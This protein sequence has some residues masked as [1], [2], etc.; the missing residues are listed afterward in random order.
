MTR[1]QSVS[2]RAFV[3]PKPEVITSLG[4]LRSFLA[5]VCSSARLYVE[6]HGHRLSRQGDLSLIAVRAYPHPEVYVIDIQ[7]L[8]HEAFTTRSVFGLTLQSI[9]ENKGLRKVFWDVRD[10]ADALWGHHGVRLEGV[11]DLQLLE[12]ASRHSPRCQGWGRRGSGSASSPSQ[13]YVN[14]LDAA[15]RRDLYLPTAEREHIARLRRTV[16]CRLPL[17]AFRLRP[18]DDDTIAFCANGIRYLP[19]LRTVYMERITCEWLPK[20]KVETARRLEAAFGPPYN[21]ESP[22]RTLGPWGNEKKPGPLFR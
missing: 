12:N 16:T 5:T 1:T 20:V 6:L 2:R 15:V 18:L 13:T 8:G 14:D 3:P 7:S 4:S 10:A 17:T 9:L 22:S 19:Q 11:V 21:P